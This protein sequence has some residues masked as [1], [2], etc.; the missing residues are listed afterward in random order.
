MRIFF[1]HT[2]NETFTRIDHDLLAAAFTVEGFHA[3]RKFP[4]DFF[5][6]WRGV[7]NCD[8]VFCWFAS[9]NSL[10]TLLLARILGKRS[11]LVIGGYDLANLPAANYGHQRGGVAQWI[12]RLAMQL[13][14]TVFTNSYYSQKE[15]EQNAGIAP[16]R[17][18]V[19]YHGVPDPFGELPQTPKE[20]LALTVGNVDYPNL[21]RKGLEPFVRAA[22]FLPAVQFVVVGQW[23]DDAIAYLKTIAAPNV[24]FTGRVSNEELLDYYRRAAVYVQA[25]LH[26]GFGMSVAEA[27]LAGCIPVVTR[28]GAL[29][30]VAGE[31]GVYCASSDP[32]GLAAAVTSALG[33]PTEACRAARQRIRTSFPL[34]QRQALLL[35]LIRRFDQTA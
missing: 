7:K 28:A 15:A 26:E 4:A 23:A 17:V 8:A 10:W 22:E 35:Q 21:K 1:V 16:E 12:S 34:E 5:T 19:I 27:M 30:E 29:P 18:Q 24:T 25:S 33:M 11:V 3:A 9:W 13:A 31:C 32:A 2:G 14:D 6:Y 20:R